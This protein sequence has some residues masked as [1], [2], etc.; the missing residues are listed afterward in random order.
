VTGALGAND[1]LVEGVLPV[2]VKPENHRPTGVTVVNPT[3][4][5]TAY[6]L[7]LLKAAGIEVTK[8]QGEGVTP[9]TGT[10]ELARHTSEP[11]SEILKK[12]NKPS[13]NLIAECLLKTLGAEKGGKVGSWQAGAAAAKEWFKSAGIDAAGVVIED[14]SGLSRHNFVTPRSYAM[15]LKTM[16]THPYAKVFKD[17]LPIPG[18][19][20]TLR[21]RTIG[22]NARK[23]ARAKT[24][25]LSNMSSLS[26]YV[27]TKTGEPLLFVI[28]MNNHQC[29]AAAARGIQ[30]KIVEY[31]ASHD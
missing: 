1:I 24:G 27:E 2:D 12:M 10:V 6:L 22:P 8:G 9:T 20:G 3:H 13:D 25:S 30:D 14:G 11:L 15:M 7:S 31:L 26:G 18:E 19:E 23:T 21:N 5:A 29:P 28:F 17:S 4:Y 16:H